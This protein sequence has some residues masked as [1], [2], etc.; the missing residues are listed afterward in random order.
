MFHRARIIA[1]KDLLEVRRD[2]KTLAFLVLSAWLLPLLAVVSQSLESSIVVH[3]A[4]VDM[5]CRSVSLGNV[6]VSSRQVAE[7]ILSLLRIASPQSRVSLYSCRRPPRYADVVVILPRG[8]VE[9]LTSFKSPAYILLLY[10]PGSQAARNVYNL[11]RYAIIPLVSREESK[12]L[13]EVLAGRARLTINPDIVLNPVRVETG[14]VGVSLSAGRRIEEAVEAAHVLAFATIFVLA[15]ASMLSTD[16]IAGERERRSLELLFSTPISPSELLAG[17]MI[18][19]TLVAVLAGLLDSASMVTYLWLNGGRIAMPEAAL[20]AVH[21][22]STI[23]AIM[24]TAAL[25]ALTVLSGVPSRIATL[26]SS[27]YTLLAFFVYAASLTV[28]YTRL[29]LLYQALLSLIPYTYSVNAVIEA[30]RG[31][32]LSAV[33][34][35]TALTAYTILAIIAA[36]WIASP[37]RVIRS[38]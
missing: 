19:S 38:S 32:I 27:L 1:W 22:A 5:D 7:T 17:K 26:A 20:L 21:V 14:F 10:N 29:P 37:E 18:A 8:F 35:L 2:R 11:V 6:T 13:I 36:A 15:P 30:A 23:L 16:L 3:V 31:K 28:D 34:S 24:V 25:T 33:M 4:V 9:N 12:K